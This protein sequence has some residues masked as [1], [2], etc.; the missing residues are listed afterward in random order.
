VFRVE[1]PDGYDIVARASAVDLPGN[2]S[3]YY[4]PDDRSVHVRGWTN[5]PYTAQGIGFVLTVDLLP[6][7]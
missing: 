4:W 5:D 1:A 6:L 3:A 2:V 7:V